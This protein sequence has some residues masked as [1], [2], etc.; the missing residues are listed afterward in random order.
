M[1]PDMKDEVGT[2]DNRNAWETLVDGLEPFPSASSAWSPA[3]VS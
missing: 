1:S 3:E 2:D